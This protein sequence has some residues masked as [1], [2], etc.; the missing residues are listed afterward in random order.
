MLA[1]F[2]THWWQYNF[3]PPGQPVWMGAAW[4]NVAAVLPLAV[5]GVV[6][7]VW[8]R[9]AMKELHGKVDALAT[10][11]DA[12]V[13]TLN[14]QH[15]GNA[16][17]LKKILDAVDPETDG[18]IGVVLDRLDVSTPGGIKDVLDAVQAKPRPAPTARSGKAPSE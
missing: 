8:H 4:P 6:G 15:A 12:H 14:A 17:R 2:F 5:L 3:A 18:G 16:D 13:A 1:L 9:G 11:H 7:W 10:L